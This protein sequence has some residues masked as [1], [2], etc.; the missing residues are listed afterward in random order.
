MAMQPGD[1]GLTPAPLAP[2]APGGPPVSAALYG[3]PYRV[4]SI[5]FVLDPYEYLEYKYHLVE[6]AS[7]VFSWVA[8][9]RLTHDFHGELDGNPEDVRSYD[10]NPTSGAHGAFTAP[11]TGIHGW[12]WENPGNKRIT[13]RLTSAGF[14]SYGMEFRSDKSRKRHEMDVVAPPPAQP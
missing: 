4:D 11:L 14:Y 10:K 2:A 13:I 9:S 8:D 3:A 6:G 5:E 1:A 12:F 7:M